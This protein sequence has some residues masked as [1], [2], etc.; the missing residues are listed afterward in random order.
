MKKQDAV[1]IGIVSF[2]V[3]LAYMPVFAWMV[4][5][6][7]AENTYYSHGFLIP[8]VS[9]FAV[10]LRR[11]ELGSAKFAPLNAGWVFF[12]AGVFMY[13]LSALW[14]VYFSAGF[15]LLAVLAG[16]ILLFLGRDYLKQLLFPLLFLSFMIPIPMIA[17]TNTSIRLKIFAA[18]VATNIVNMLGIRAVRDGSVIRTAH[19]YLM[20]EDPCSGIRSLIALIALG[21]LMA[22][23]SSLTRPRKILLFL[24]SIPIAILS[25]SIRIVALTMVSEMYG[26][27]AAMGALHELT[28]MLV[29]VLAFL[30]LAAAA[31][32]LE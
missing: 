23:F 6:W 15:S 25:N 10:W 1:K 22:Y 11:K 16:L 24:L 14:Q 4:N 28:A 8:L 20:V 31:K 17:I 21:V 7:T 27:K 30:S 12:L 2:V 32:L 19:S 29:F 5:R 9:I 3:M 18:Q 13:A 26:A